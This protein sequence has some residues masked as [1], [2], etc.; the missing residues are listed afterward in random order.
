MINKISPQNIG[1]LGLYS[2]APA[3]EEL[4]RDAIASGNDKIDEWVYLSKAGFIFD[5]TYTS[6]AAELL[7]EIGASDM[8]VANVVEAIKQDL[9]FLNLTCYFDEED[10]LEGFTSHPWSGQ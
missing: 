1:T 10:E 6:S 2:M 8:L 3:D 9:A 4:L 7:K 5:L